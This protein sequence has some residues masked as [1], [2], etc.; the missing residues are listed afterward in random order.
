MADEWILLP[1]AIKAI[2]DARAIPRSEAI[3]LTVSLAKNGE[4]GSRIA[5]EVNRSEGQPRRNVPMSNAH[6]RD[7]EKL[8][9]AWIDTG[10]AEFIDGYAWRGIQIHAGD[11]ALSHPQVGPQSQGKLQPVATA[12]RPPKSEAVSDV[13]PSQDWIRIGEA[14]RSLHQVLKDALS[15]QEPAPWIEKPLKITEQEETETSLRHRQ[16]ARTS[17]TMRRGLLSGDLTAHLV[18]GDQSIPVPCWAWENAS[19]SEN[20]FH[21]SWLP[22]DPFRDHGLSD[23]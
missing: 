11:L 21:F 5:L 14:V 2:A 10:N 16:M 3:P 8:D 12:N 15:A 13:E 17:L 23:R 1:D 20:A 19:A 9:T 18:S 6:W 7:L 22:L 4:V